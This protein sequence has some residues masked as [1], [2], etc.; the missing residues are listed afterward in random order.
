MSI[1][2]PR[3][4]CLVL[5]EKNVYHV[6]IGICDDHL[7]V[8]TAYVPDEEQWI[9]TTNE[10]E[11]RMIPERCTFCKGTLREGKTKIHCTGRG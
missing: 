2:A 4:S 6:V 1:P 8:I 10:E 3:C 7:R 9:D 5:Y 11:K